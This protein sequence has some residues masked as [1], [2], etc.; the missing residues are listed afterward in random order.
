MSETLMVQ[1]LRPKSHVLRSDEIF[2]L[3]EPL[4]QGGNEDVEFS[5]LGQRG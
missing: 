3:K 5:Y 4:K 1:F 2:F